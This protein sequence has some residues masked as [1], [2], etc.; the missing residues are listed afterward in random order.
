M[1]D[2]IVIP[3]YRRIYRQETFDLLPEK[4]REKTVL[5]VHPCEAPWHIEQGRNVIVTGEQGH[6]VYRIRKFI[7]EHFA[8]QRIVMMDDDV[9]QIELYDPNQ[10]D[11]CDLSDTR[12]FDI[13]FQTLDSALDVY[14][15]AMIADPKLTDSYLDPTSYSV[16]RQTMAVLQAFNLERIPQDV[17]QRIDTDFTNVQEDTYLTLHFLSYGSSQIYFHNYRWQARY[18]TTGGLEG[19]RVM[20]DSL[21]SA[22]LV[23]DKFVGVTIGDDADPNNSRIPMYID[24]DRLWRSNL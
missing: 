21:T 13:F 3:T 7:L 23:A 5:V 15:R 12:G 16:N 22:S 11:W 4:W 2:K 17:V 10:D 20:S 8:G 14:D 19:M 24:Y 6:G 1:I 18:W 9:Y